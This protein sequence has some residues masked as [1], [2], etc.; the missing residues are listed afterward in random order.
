ML[1][2]FYGPRLTAYELR[3]KREIE[4]LKKEA[5]E[6]DA[7]ARFIKAVLAGS[8]EL[9]KATDEEIVA[10]MKKHSLPPISKPD[11]GDEVEAYEYLLR[12]R[13]DRVKA[14]AVKEQELAVEVARASVALLEGT[15]AE[16]LWL[17][18]LDEFLLAWK[19]MLQARTEALADVDGKKRSGAKK[20]FAV[21]KA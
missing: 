4:R 11:M 17:K 20:K 18:D 8:L 21:K 1:E 6:H 12:M 19:A 10:M 7:K 14:S 13:M 15:R 9:R 3:R 16:D 5:V 2:G